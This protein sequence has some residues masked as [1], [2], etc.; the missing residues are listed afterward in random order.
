MIRKQAVGNNGQLAINNE[1]LTNPSLHPST[2]P[3]LHS[4]TLPPFLALLITIFAFT[5]RLRTLTLFNFH[6][7]EFFTLA[8][9][10]FIAQSGAPI[11]PTGLFYDPGLPYSYFTGALFRLLGFSEAL[12]RW[13]A[14]LF[15]TLGVA[16]L[17]WLGLRILRSPWVGLL[18][19]FWLAVSFDSVTWSGRARMISLAQWLALLS[20]GLLWVGLTHDRA[21]Y[22]LGLAGTYALTLLSHFATVVLM[23]AWFAAGAGLWAL[24][25]V[26]L[27]RDLGRDTLILAVAFALAISAGVLFQPPPSPDFAVG[28][29]DLGPKTGALT[30]KFLQIPSDFG[31]AWD[32]YAPY[33]LN[34][35]YGPL[36]LIGLVGLVTSL[37]R[38]RRGQRHARDIGAFFTAAVFLTTLAVLTL[39]IAPHWQRERYLLMQL[40][41]PFLLLAAHG[42]REVINLLPS[43]PGLGN[44]AEGS[45]RLRPNLSL[46]QWAGAA[47]LAGLLSLAALPP[48]QELLEAGPTGWNRYDQALAY[49]R[50]HW[51]DGDQLM[52]MHPP[53]ALIYLG[54]DDFYLDQSS[55]KLIRRPDGQ[56]GNRYSGALWLD[57]AA[58]FNPVLAHSRRVWLVTQEFW[59]FNSYDSYLQQQILWQMDKLWGEGGV[60]A[61]GSRPDRWPLAPQPQHPINAEFDGGAR[62]LGYTAEPPLILP[63]GLVR[64]TFFWQGNV[65]YGAKVMVHL[66]DSANTTVAQADHFI[67]D[68]KVPASRWPTLLA[69]AA[70]LRDGVTLALP[71]EL[72]T[73]TYRL[74]VGFYHPETF[75]RL[76]VINDQSGESAVIVAAWTVPLP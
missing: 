52:T 32:N 56:L 21:R 12:G 3:P 25:V 39:A 55:P 6:M 33:F 22:R 11:Y 28:A 7:D 40:L 15:G 62:L 34:W 31:H 27:S 76:G 5:L 71:A 66:R 8:A 45:R 17:Y 69:N 37:S 74:L 30:E 43:I 23:P 44:G 54:Q 68:G 63:G 9:A 1:Q 75:E 48:L 36:L 67:Y 60:W 26:R 41:G 20:L 65:P 72:S 53:A 42:C 19:A 51:T 13:P 61:L 59:L 46:S 10:K 16:T 4:S 70:A 29:A 58:Q 47:L 64:L 57:S 38:L 14:V 2:P 49:V 24:G 73:G 18:A 35:T 50:D